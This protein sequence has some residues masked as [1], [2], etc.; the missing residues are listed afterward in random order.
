MFFSKLVLK[1][2]MAA[3][4]AVALGG[5]CSA[6][7]LAVG[8]L[9]F[10]IVVPDAPNSP[11]VVGLSILNLTGD[12]L[13]GGSAI[14]PDFRI[15]SELTLQNVLISVLLSSG[16]Q[17]IPLPDLPPG[18]H[19]PPE[20]QFAST[21]EIQ[22]IT[23]QALLNAVDVALDDGSPA[24]IQSAAVLSTLGPSSGIYLQ[25]GIDLQTVQVEAQ[26]QTT[27]IPEPGAVWLCGSGL[28]AFGLLRWRSR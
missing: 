1:T 15:Y 10:E 16:T 12:P 5:V 27:P 11:G 6:G 7:Q 22:S 18:T 2:L 24:T 28:V 3:A 21:V 23:L 14:P 26:I 19:T 20:L 8:V 17:D 13:L 9:S 25:A 4:T